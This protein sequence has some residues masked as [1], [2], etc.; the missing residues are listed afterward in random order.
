MIEQ[1]AYIRMKKN[2]VPSNNIQHLSV[3]TTAIKREFHVHE[4]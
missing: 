2:Y 3:T 4:H 1:N